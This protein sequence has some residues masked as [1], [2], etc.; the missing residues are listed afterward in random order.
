MLCWLHQRCFQKLTAET[1]TVAALLVN[2]DKKNKMIRQVEIKKP[3]EPD[4]LIIYLGLK[5]KVTASLRHSKS[6][7]VTL[8][9]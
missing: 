4:Y 3:A 6:H 9:G 8:T 5:M 1:L 7:G 2:R